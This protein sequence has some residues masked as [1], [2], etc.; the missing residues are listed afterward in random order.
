M[1]KEQHTKDAKVGG[2]LKND[3]YK[4]AFRKS[5]DDATRLPDWPEQLKRLKA[6]P[7]FN[8]KIFE[9]I[10]GITA[11]ELTGSTVEKLTTKPKRKRKQS[12]KGA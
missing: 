2:Y 12:T 3:D 4:V 10:S 6:L 7:N 5:F 1:G 9:E 11:E 8:F